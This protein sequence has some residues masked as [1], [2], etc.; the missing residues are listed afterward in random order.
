MKKTKILSSLTLLLLC[1]SLLLASCGRQVKDALLGDDNASGCYNDGALA[2]EITTVP[3]VNSTQSETVNLKGYAVVYPAGASDAFVSHVR[4]L[5]DAIE[6]ITCETVTVKDDSAAQT[7][8]EILVGKT[9]RTL[10]TNVASAITGHGFRIELSGKKIVIAGSTNLFALMGADHLLA[11]YL[12][13]NGAVRTSLPCSITAQGY[14]IITLGSDYTVVYD[15]DLDTDGTYRNDSDPY[16]E[17]NRVSGTG[18]DLAYDLAARVQSVA[19]ASIT[20]DTAITE[21]AEK[22]ILVGTPAHATVTSV[23]DG[24][25]KNEYVIA[26]RDGHVIVSGWNLAAQQR[27]AELLAGTST[28]I[29]GYLQDALDN[30]GNV[31][32]PEGLTLR[33]AVNVTWLTDAD[34]TLPTGLTLNTTCDVEDGS[35]LYVYTGEGTDLAAYQTYCNTL[36]SN[37]YR[38]LSQTSAEGSYFATLVHYDKGISLNVSYFAFAHKEELIGKHS[39]SSTDPYDATDYAPQLRVVAASLFCV[40]LPDPTLLSPVQ[41]YEKLTS[42]K[43]TL[44]SIPSDSVGTGY[45][46][47]LEDGRFIVIDGGKN[48]TGLERDN[49]WHVLSTLYEQAHGKAPADADGERVEI[50]AWVITHGH[51]DHYYCFW[52]FC[53]KYGGTHS[54]SVGAMVEIEYVITNT[55]SATQ[56]YNSGE[57]STDLQSSLATINSRVAHGFTHIKAHTGQTMYFANVKMETLFTQEDLWPERIVNMNDASLINRF[58][59]AS[60]GEAV[61][62]NVTLSAESWNEQDANGNDNAAVTTFMSTGDAYLIS[63][64]FACAMYGDFLASDMVSLAH[65]GSVGAEAFFYDKVAPTTVLV[66]HVRSSIYGYWLPLNN[67]YMG[68][69]KHVLFELSSVQYIF[70]ADDLDGIDTTAPTLNITIDLTASGAQYDTAHDVGSTSTVDSYTLHTS[71]VVSTS[72]QLYT[73]RPVFIKRTR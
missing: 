25:A 19:A 42:S 1:L 73:V 18:R 68:V 23:L 70:L 53:T 17:F 16:T 7:T 43:L 22:L 30:A 37:G 71:T 61:G 3:V 66:P 4:K 51:S 6:A 54:S 24:C 8:K 64:R 65:H 57:A 41:T 36:V 5:A 12:G 2:D 55:P 72:H 50:A 52:D 26:V 33:G 27:A 29:T 46:M 31:V 48:A 9:S 32:L 10:S 21:N 59:F 34:L 39:A 62:S 38:L 13:E 14:E 63:S 15:A 44:V 58:S 28:E 40:N 35:L 11:T 60:T 20:T 69:T 49:L 47:M 67:W 45:V 56:I